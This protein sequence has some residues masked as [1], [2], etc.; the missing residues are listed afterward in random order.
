LFLLTEILVLVEPDS[1]RCD[2]NGPDIVSVS[3]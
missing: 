3:R 1:G 2:R